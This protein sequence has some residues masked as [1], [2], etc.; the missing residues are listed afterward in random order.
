[1]AI[2]LPPSRPHQDARDQ[3]EL[4]REAENVHDA[5]EAAVEASDLRAHPLTALLGRNPEFDR[6]RLNI[7]LH[8]AAEDELAGGVHQIG[9]QEQH[10]DEQQIAI[11]A[12][13]HIRREAPVAERVAF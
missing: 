8:R 9:E 12:K 6:L 13:A 10:R 1:M 5:E 11:A 3:E 4:D 2:R 7:C